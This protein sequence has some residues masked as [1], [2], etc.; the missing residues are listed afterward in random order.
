[1]KI[2]FDVSIRVI[3]TPKGITPAHL[4][5]VSSIVIP[6]DTDADDDSSFKSFEH[7]MEHPGARSTVALGNKVAHHKFTW[8]PTEPSDQDWR[9]VKNDNIVF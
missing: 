5:E 6:I 7:A 1:M 2:M 9:L 4:M 8:W 3:T